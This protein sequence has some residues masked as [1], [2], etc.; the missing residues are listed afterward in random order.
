V[1]GCCGQHGKAPNGGA[2]VPPIYP[3]TGCAMCAEKH[4]SLAFAL[5]GE[6]G[7]VPVNRQRIV[8]EL[9]AAALH[10]FKDHAELAEKVR[11]ARHLIQERREADVEWEPLL[12]EMDAL[13]SKQAEENK[14]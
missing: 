2:R 12:I 4:L 1:S 10:L 6:A 8:G 14:K 5:A 7:Y 11:A 13:A 9:G 3:A